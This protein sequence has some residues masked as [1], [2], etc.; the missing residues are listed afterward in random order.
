MSSAY[1]SL[2]ANSS[3]RGMQY[4]TFPMLCAPPTV[5]DSLLS[6]LDHG[7]IV[8]KP[9]IDRFDRNRAITA[10]RY[11]RSTRHAIGVDFLAYLREIRRERQAGA[12]RNG[13]SR[14]PL[15]DSPKPRILRP[16]STPSPRGAAV[17]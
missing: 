9:N 6:K 17:R 10:R 8:V 14:A 5:S 1:R 16:A 12:R 7:D 4:A 3:R 13:A 15:A 2:H 11:A